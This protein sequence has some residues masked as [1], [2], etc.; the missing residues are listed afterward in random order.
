MI[1]NY[2]KK[3]FNI[4]G[5]VVDSCFVSYGN[6]IK[7]NYECNKDDENFKFL[8]GILIREINENESKDNNTGFGESDN[9]LENNPNK[10][11]EECIW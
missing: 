2:E 9:C 6:L 3:I 1:V 11:I 7:M 10:I 8:Q 4:Q 5:Q